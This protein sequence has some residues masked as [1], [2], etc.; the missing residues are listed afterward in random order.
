MAPRVRLWQAKLPPGVGVEL[1]RR[2]WLVLAEAERQTRMQL[3]TQTLP[4]VRPV[5]CIARGSWP[6]A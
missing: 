5:F 3:Q 4:P 1:E 2:G 6:W